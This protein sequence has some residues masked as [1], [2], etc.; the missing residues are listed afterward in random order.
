MPTAAYF[1]DCG[2]MVCPNVSRTCFSRRAMIVRG[3]VCEALTLYTPSPFVVCCWEY[4]VNKEEVADF[5]RKMMSGIIQ[6][7]FE[8]LRRTDANCR[9][10]KKFFQSCSLWMFMLAQWCNCDL[11]WIGGQLSKT[12]N[13]FRNDWFRGAN[14]NVLKTHPFT[15][16]CGAS[17]TNTIYMIPSTPHTYTYS[18]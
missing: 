18:I 11:V 13:N 7:A 6:T 8:R 10:S 9:D 14:C 1:C 5:S 16:K 4:H 3:D 15:V 2:V 17:R 12:R